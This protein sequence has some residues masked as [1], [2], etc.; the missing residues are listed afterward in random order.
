MVRYFCLGAEPTCRKS[1]RFWLL[2][3]TFPVCRC[4]PVGCENG[5]PQ[6]CECVEGKCQPTHVQINAVRFRTAAGKY[7][8][9][10]GGGE[11][12][13]GEGPTVP[14]QLETFRFDPDPTWP[15]FSGDHISLRVCG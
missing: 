11:G 3:Q 13:L 15:L 4:V 14:Q 1:L 8:H 12:R 6:W 9:A 5:C 7:L 10:L 2:P